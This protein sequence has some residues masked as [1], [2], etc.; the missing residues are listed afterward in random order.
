MRRAKQFYQALYRFE[1]DCAENSNNLRKF[2]YLILNELILN[3]SKSCSP[4]FSWKVND[5][6]ILD[7]NIWVFGNSIL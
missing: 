5:E 4:N 6:Q 1:P 2:W 3:Y 7:Y